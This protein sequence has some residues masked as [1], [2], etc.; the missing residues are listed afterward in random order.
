MTA[1]DA[2][3]ED[4]PLLV[5]HFLSLIAAQQE[6]PLKTVAP[7]VLNHLMGLQWPGNIRQMENLISEDNDVVCAVVG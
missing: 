2:I 1:I 4:I 3:R 7:E 6:N 5:D